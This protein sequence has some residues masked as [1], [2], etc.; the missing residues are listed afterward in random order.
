MFDWVVGIAVGVLLLALVLT[1]T[2]LAL[3]PSLPDRVIALDLFSNLTIGVLAVF[4]IAV[5]QPALLD[6]AITL[7]LV[8]FLATAAFARYIEQSAARKGGEE[9][10]P[11]S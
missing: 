5:D 10:S 8:S 1:F 4:A 6:A 3:G 11:P 2:R 9:R 7:A